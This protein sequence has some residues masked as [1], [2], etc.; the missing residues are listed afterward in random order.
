LA[1][2]KGG[3]ATALQAWL[4]PH[5]QAGEEEQAGGCECAVQPPEAAVSLATRSPATFLLLQNP[6]S[7]EVTGESVPLGQA[8]VPAALQV[9]PPSL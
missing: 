4:A 9:L 1:P 6:Q 7:F 5:L 8:Q 3:C 2:A